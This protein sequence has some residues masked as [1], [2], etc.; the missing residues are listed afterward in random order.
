MFTF[1]RIMII[2]ANKFVTHIIVA[3]TKISISFDTDKIYRNL[4][5]YGI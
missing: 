5:T 1:V 4:I 3:W 2:D